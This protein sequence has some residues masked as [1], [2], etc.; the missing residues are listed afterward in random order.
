MRNRT[1]SRAEGSKIKKALDEFGF[2]A[3]TDLREGLQKTVLWY[4]QSRFKAEPD[5]NGTHAEQASATPRV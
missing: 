3:R 2:R 5:G 4:E 1:D